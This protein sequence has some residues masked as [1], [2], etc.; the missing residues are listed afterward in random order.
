MVDVKCFA[1][2]VVA[3]VIYTACTEDALA[4]SAHSAESAE[5]V[6]PAGPPKDVLVAL[7]RSAYAAWK[8]KDVKFWD[9]FLADNF[10]G[11]GTSGKLDKGSAK[12]EYSGADCDIKSYALSE[13]RVSPRGQRAALITYKASVDGTCG[14][15]KIPANSWVASVYVRD[16]G[17]W[18]AV[19]HAQDAVVNPE[20]PPVRAVGQSGARQNAT[21]RLTAQDAPTAALLP[22]ERAVWEAWKDHDAERMSKLLAEDISFINIFGIYLA[23][24]AEAL[25]NWSGTGC[26]VTS[27]GVTDAVATMLSPKV[28][29]LTF[30]ATA[31]GTC[32]GQKVGP[33]WG[34]SIYVKYGHAWK[35]TFGINVPARGEST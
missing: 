8:S 31:D 29:I 26:D 1:L 10:V 15:Q 14:G 25:K 11:W 9:R 24:K 18:K 5:Q 12:K 6:A 7:E 21:A 19:F 22:V 32:F 35:W 2:A 23:N 28:G 34:S 17:Q 16:G 20:L 33:I 27:V 13:E 30:R 3:V 4:N